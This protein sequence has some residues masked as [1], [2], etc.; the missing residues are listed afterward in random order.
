MSRRTKYRVTLD[1]EARMKAETISAEGNRALQLLD[2]IITAGFKE[3]NE[4]LGCKPG[5]SP[6]VHGLTAMGIEDIE[7]HPVVFAAIDI[8]A[9]DEVEALSVVTAIFWNGVNKTEIHGTFSFE[10]ATI[11]RI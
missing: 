6:Y 1:F 7:S 8:Y 2:K 9:Q 11:K 10:K 3:E 5:S 4:P